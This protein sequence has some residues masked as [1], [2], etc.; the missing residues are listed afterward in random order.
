VTGTPL[1]GT[2][3]A[4]DLR[5]QALL[6]D[7]LLQRV[8]GVIA[9]LPSDAVLSGWWGPAR[10]RFLEAVERERADLGRE[11]YRL[12]GVRTQLQ[13]AASLAESGLP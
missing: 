1:T 13:H 4:T 12:D 8:A 6:V 2:H 11:V 5:R 10:E 9:D 3:A 7:T